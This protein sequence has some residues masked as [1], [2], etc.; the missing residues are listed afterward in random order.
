M[1]FHTLKKLLLR[2][3]NSYVKKHLS[4]LF[5]SLLLSMG[6]A[7]STATIAWLL[8]P[9]IKKMFIEQDRSMMLLIPLAIF[10]SFLVKGSTLYF[11]RTILIKIGN[12][13][14]KELQ[15]QLSESVLKS[16]TH[17][18][19]SKHSGKFVSHFLYS[20]LIMLVCFF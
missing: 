14:V 11:A 19:E 15:N 1:K 3:Y 6:V 12:A 20:R 7:G 4:K 5:V 8:D 17:T 13:V 9:A 10:I 18:L 2:L 16:D